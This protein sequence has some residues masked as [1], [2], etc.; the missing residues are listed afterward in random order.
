MARVTLTGFSKLLLNLKK[1]ISKRELD[2]I[3]APALETFRGNL[4]FRIHNDGESS[5]GAEIGEPPIAESRTGVYEKYYGRKRRKKGRQVA[6]KDLE[7]TGE[8]RRSVKHGTRNRNQAIYIEGNRNQI[9]AGAQEEQ[10]KKDI[11][12]PSRLELDEFT[13][14]ITEELTNRILSNF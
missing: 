12:E 7:M 4:L 5:N 14:I 1:D 3:V 11:Y 2:D 6:K 10:T 9:I 13:E 8:L